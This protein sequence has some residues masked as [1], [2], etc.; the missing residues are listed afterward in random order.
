M[1]KPVVRLTQDSPEAV[2]HWHTVTHIDNNVGQLL[3]A[4]ELIRVCP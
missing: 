1:A 4:F 3:A 2:L